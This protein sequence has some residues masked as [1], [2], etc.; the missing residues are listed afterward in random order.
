MQEGG[1]KE[2]KSIAQQVACLRFTEHLPLTAVLPLLT[3]RH[4]K[5]GSILIRKLFAATAVT[6]LSLIT[7]PLPAQASAYSGTV[8]GTLS[9][10]ISGSVISLTD[11]I[12]FSPAASPV[13]VSYYACYSNDPGRLTVGTT[14]FQGCN[15]L[16]GDSSGSTVVIPSNDLANAY[17]KT[18][19]SQYS[20]YHVGKG[21]YIGIQYRIGSAS[22]RFIISPTVQTSLPADP[23]AGPVI[24]TPV[25][26]AAAGGAPVK[27]S[28]PEFSGLSLKPALAGSSATLEGRKLDQIASVTIGGKAAKLSDATDKSVNIG[29]PAGLA[30]GVYDLVVTT[31]SHGKLTH[32]NAI[33]IREELP[34]TSLTIKGSGVLSGEEF[35][36]LTAFSRT[37]NPDMNT[38]TCIVNSN[39]EGKSFTQ[40]RALCDRIAASNLNIKT[41]MFENRSTVQGS[42]IFARV[43]FS[44]EK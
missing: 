17:T 18:G 7:G 21:E 38:A 42:A 16:F 14:G 24:S 41:T 11:T 9:L 20:R 19:I 39:S 27:Y 6:A 26:Q 32:M 44:S 36:R 28:G 33:R 40:A 13:E 43:V 10:S 29:L 23:G 37:Q 4:Q 2:F 1:A 31:V 5:N 3:F 30:P 15:Q 8:S 25:Q 34:E 22:Y 12:A 35:K